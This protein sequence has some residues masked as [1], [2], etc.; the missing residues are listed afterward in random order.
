MITVGLLWDGP[1]TRGN[2]G[3][4]GAQDGRELG[5]IGLG[6]ELESFYLPS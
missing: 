3:Q 1:E 6:L 5:P 2:G 4:A